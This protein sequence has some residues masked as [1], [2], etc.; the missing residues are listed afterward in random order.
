MCSILFFIRDKVLFKNSM[1]KVSH[2]IRSTWN[3]VTFGN[4]IEVTP[5]LMTL[6]P[7]P[8]DLKRVRPQYGD[9]LECVI[10]FYWLFAVLFNH[11]RFCS[12]YYLHTHTNTN[13]NEATCSEFIRYVGH[14]SQ[15][16][17]FWKMPTS[18]NSIHSELMSGTLRYRQPCHRDNNQIQCQLGK[19]L[20][21][22]KRLYKLFSYLRQCL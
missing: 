19:Q 6:Y 4:Y 21:L 20:G 8:S 2:A 18:K 7:L 3:I 12:L 14:Q 16:K 22:D 5:I 13:F 15:K 9:L 1:N 10:R 17:K 11:S